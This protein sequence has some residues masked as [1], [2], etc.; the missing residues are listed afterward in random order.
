MSARAAL[1]NEAR[2]LVK[3]YGERFR[4]CGTEQVGLDLAMGLS[5]ELREALEPMLREI[6]SLNER[7]KE[8]DR[9]IEKM[10]NLLVVLLNTAHTYARKVGALTRLNLNWL[11]S[12]QKCV[13]FSS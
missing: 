12:I 1:V 6:E 13:Y 5:A 10:A 2:G 7:I 4:K 8:Y 3:S 11:A 9:R